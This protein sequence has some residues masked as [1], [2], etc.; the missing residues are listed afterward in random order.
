MKNTAKRKSL[1]SRIKRSLCLLAVI[2][3]QLTLSGV[4]AQTTN[5]TIQKKNITVK[6]VLT[7]IE[8]NSQ[9]VFFYAD[10]DVDLN[11]KVSIDVKNQPISKV[12]EE[13]FK[14]SLNA[15]KLDGN[16]V[17]ISKKQKQ[18]E[19]KVKPANKTN[20]ISGVITDEK[21][22]SIIG[23][24]VMLNGTSVGTFT[25]VNGRFSLEAP[26]NGQLKI[27]YLG[28][29]T[30]LVDLEGRTSLNILFSESTKNL[31]EVVVVGYGT[32]KKISVTGAIS[33]VGNELL[34]KSPNA[35]ISNTLAGRVTGLSTI[36]YSGQ[37][38]ADAPE[39][40][41]R[42]L[43]SLTTDGSA[44]L[45]LVDGVERSFDQLDPNEV[46]S[47]SILKDASATAVYGIRGAN[48]VILVT[49]RRGTEGAPKI[50]FTTSTGVQ[51]PSRLVKLADSYTYAT[52]FNEA[53]LS[54]NPAANLMF[55][56][57]TIEAFKTGSN[58]YI[59]PNT[60]WIGQIVKPFSPQ[61]QYNINIT[62]GSKEVK[63]FVSLGYLNQEGQFNTFG[64]TNATNFGYKR[65]NYR[66]NVDLQMT[67]TTTLSFTTGGRIETGQSPFGNSSIFYGIYQT[68]P[69]SGFVL[70][71]KSY[72]IGQ[73]QIGMSGI[74]DGADV[75]ALGRG[76]T[77]STYNTMNLDVALIQKLDFITKGLNWR[78]KYSNNSTIG[79]QKTRYSSTAS[80]QPNYLTDIPGDNFGKGDSTVVFLKNGV[81]G[82]LDYGESSSVS[83]NWYAE[84]AFSYD[85]TLGDHQVTGLL[86]YNES[87]SYYPAIYADIPTGYVGFAAR[88]TYNY[89]SKYLA[90]FN[91]GYNGS[92]NFAPGNRFG[93]F[94]AVSVGWV[95]TEE[96]FLKD[97]ISFLD[98]LKFRM[99]Y[100]E[101]GNDK[102]GSSRFLYLPDSYLANTYI[103]ES[104]WSHQY[105]GYSF[106]INNPINQTVAGEGK[107]G[108]PGVTWEVAKKTNIG[109][110]MK[111]FKGKLGITGDV[112]YEYRNNILTTR[113]TVPSLLAINLPTVNIGS[114]ENKG[115]EVELKWRDN[116]GKLNYYLTGNVSFARNKILYIDEIPKN[117]PYLY[118]TGNRVGQ[119]F[120]YVFSGFWNANEVAHY[121]DLDA[122]GKRITP[123]Y[124]Y[125]PKPGDSKYT[126]LNSDGKINSD[127]QKAIGYP[128]YPEFNFSLSG[129][130]SY[131]GFDIS[132]MWTGVTDVSRVLNETWR[133]AFGATQNR[134]LLQWLSDNS[135]TPETANTAILPRISFTSLTNN[136]K[137][138]TLWLRDASYIRLKNLEIGY[139]F[140]N[141]TLKKLGISSIRIYTNGYNLL[142]F[143]Y[144]KFMDPEQRTTTPDYPMITIYNLGLNVNF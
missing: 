105:D 118:Y 114:V 124:G 84:T 55:S 44:P 13:L 76:Y 39:I 14:N 3:A 71:G 18:V 96:K 11:R 1:K 54:D 50:S 111:L 100:G 32:Q 28:Y 21:N 2:F 42:G 137:T 6:E 51:V 30:Q 97:K 79:L 135:W 81:D 24:I 43:G 101:V 102:Q 20:K 47:I 75:I 112:F 9:V 5:L 141:G 64:V 95:V 104:S 25:D 143:D 80:Y 121:N 72:T 36:Q 78:I 136:A 38:G 138:S 16:Q 74:Y 115:F 46:E 27:S 48:G 23:V 62:G 140:D 88:A 94:P 113:N 77:S 56:S 37:P 82:S 70:D 117:E 108:N 65:Y 69:F 52:K 91:L 128:D 73:K 116:I 49:T 139:S 15:F 142:T 34:V 127:D 66:A 126:D 130:I 122:Q 85:H 92:E 60:D 7:L 41:V 68:V 144:L 35:S 98:F 132:M 109:M 120:G 53:L 106:G 8:K 86:L 45:M 59:Y 125:A 90:D 26:E 99:S 61:S 31:D 107:T 40:F 87:K 22:Q 119:P 89:K 33:T 93:F 133:D 29:E 10:K 129:G 58:P 17:Y 134:C 19:E 67:K 123:D 57:K 83:R 4:Y 103:P 12:L 63:Y 131:K 110:D